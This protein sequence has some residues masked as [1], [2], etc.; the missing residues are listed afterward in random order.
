VEGMALAV[1]H[2]GIVTFVLLGRLMRLLLPASPVVLSSAATDGPHRP[3][4]NLVLART[5]AVSL[6]AADTGF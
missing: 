1:G 3:S 4:G 6:A 2:R 5:M